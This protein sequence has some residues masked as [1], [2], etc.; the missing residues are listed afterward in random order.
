[1]YLWY[2]HWDWFITTATLLGTLKM[3]LCVFILLKQTVAV[4][5]VFEEKSVLV[6]LDFNLFNQYHVGLFSG[7]IWIDCVWLHLRIYFSRYHELITP[8]CQSK[9]RI[10]TG[11]VH[12]DSFQEA[13]NVMMLQSQIIILCAGCHKHDD[14]I[15]WTHIPRYWPFLH[16]AILIKIYKSS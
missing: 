3:S 9:A 15:K 8:Y 13:H 11:T 16:S 4:I 12:V 2:V 6:G 5:W 14:V 7:M 10:D 1:M